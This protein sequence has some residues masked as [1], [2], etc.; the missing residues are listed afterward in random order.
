MDPMKTRGKNFI[1]DDSR[2]G[3]MYAPPQTFVHK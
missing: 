1:A 3:Y 2:K